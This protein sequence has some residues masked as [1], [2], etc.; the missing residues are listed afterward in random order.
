MVTVIWGRSILSMSTRITL[1]RARINDEQFLYNLHTHPQVVRGHGLHGPI[2]AVFFKHAVEGLIPGWEHNF[3]IKRGVMHLGYA[4]LQDYSKEDRRA[5]LMVSVVPEQWSDG[6]ATLA[7]TDMMDWAMSA[8]GSGG[9]GI[10]SLWAGVLEENKGSCRLMEKLGFKQT[11]M[12]PGY[13]RYGP[14]R[15]D[16]LIFTREGLLKE[17]ETQVQPVQSVGTDVGND[18]SDAEGGGAKVD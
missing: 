13:Y 4:A 15:Y 17:D 7:V 11:G 10:E 5:N 8:I 3:V 12:I 1:T 16:R 2:P 14:R 9:L 18:R 6:V